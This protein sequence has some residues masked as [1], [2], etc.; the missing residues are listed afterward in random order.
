[1]ATESSK[2]SRATPPAASGA[3]QRWGKRLL[4]VVVGGVALVMVVPLL[5]VLA[6]AVAVAL[7]RPVLFRQRRVGL[8]G[9][10][11]VCLKFRTMHAD[12]RVAD[13]G[14]GTDGERRV[15]HKSAADPRLTP[16]GRFMRMAS[17]DELPQLVNVLRGEMSLVGPRPELPSV[18]A[19]YEPWQ[20]ARHAVK[21]GLTGLWQVS[22]RAET[23]MHDA[24]QLDIEYIQRMSL[25]TDLVILAR[26][27]PALVTQRGK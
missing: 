3:Y 12:R 24:T 13:A 25:W 21:P 16:L 19:R 17:L 27:I 23:A 9:D 6:I 4:D 11:F 2:H 18:V 10:E 8:G 26:T 15:T 20:H 7:G 14:P 22:A 1:M 5:A